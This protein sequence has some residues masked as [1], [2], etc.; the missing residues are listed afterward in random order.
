MVISSAHLNN[1]VA[2]SKRGIT[3]DLL[4]QLFQAAKDTCCDILEPDF[5]QGVDQLTEQ[6]RLWIQRQNLEPVP[7]SL[8]GH[9]DGDCCGFLVFP[10]SQLLNLSLQRH[11]SISFDH[12]HLQIRQYDADSHHP[13]FVFHTVTNKRSRG[14]MSDKRLDRQERKKANCRRNEQPEESR[15]FHSMRIMCH[16]RKSFTKLG[17]NGR[18]LWCKFIEQ[19]YRA[20]L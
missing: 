10:S 19:C 14:P 16:T 9:R 11:G 17:S 13:S 18:W 7:T 20:V 5:N 4:Q 8:L 2:S 3:R 1:V 12:R 15:C 6:F